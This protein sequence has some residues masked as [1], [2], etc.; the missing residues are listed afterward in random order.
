MRA[1]ATAPPV[2]SS[3]T[4]SPEPRLCANNSS[5]ARRVRIRPA[6][7]TRPSSAIATSQNSRCTSKPMYLMAASSRSTTRETRWANDNDGVGVDLGRGV[8]LAAGPVP[9]AALR[10]GRAGCSASGSPRTCRWSCGDQGLQ[11][12]EH[13]RG[14]TLEAALRPRRGDLGPAVAVVLDPHRAGVVEHRVAVGRPP[15][16]EVAPFQPAPVRLGVFA[17]QP[18]GNPPPCVG[19]QVAEGASGHPAAEVGT[20]AAQH[21]VEPVEQLAERLV[22][23]TAGDR[24]D[25]RLDRRKRRLGGVGVDVAAAVRGPVTLDAPAE[26]LDALV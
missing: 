7:R 21:R 25:L 24:L 13:L 4:S 15:P 17:A 26:E 11:A 1:I 18:A 12:L 9:Q 3:A 6:E 16:R 8:S 2:D 20:P 10:T 19:A 14:V 23:A 5:S 22:V